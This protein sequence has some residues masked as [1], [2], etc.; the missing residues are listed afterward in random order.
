MVKVTRRR[1]SF[2]PEGI[3]LT[4]YGV[5]GAE[6][7]PWKLVVYWRKLTLR[8]S[9][10]LEYFRGRTCCPILVRRFI[11]KYT[12]R[13]CSTILSVSRQMPCSTM[14]DNA[15][16]ACQFPHDALPEASRKKALKILT[17]LSSQACRETV[18]SVPGVA[19]LDKGSIRHFLSARM[20][21]PGETPGNISKTSRCD[22]TPLTS[23]RK[24]LKE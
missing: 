4:V 10:L 23:F 8:G 22:Y 3:S 18:L 17:E 5:P 2:D 12:F 11:E 7:F 16:T 13:I 21:S 19:R 14:H 20:G 9:L 15:Q 24:L 6:I 1:R